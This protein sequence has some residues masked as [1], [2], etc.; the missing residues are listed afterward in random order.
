VNEVRRATAR[1]ENHCTYFSLRML[2]TECVVRVLVDAG[3]DHS[4]HLRLGH[5][6][7]ADYLV[8][9]VYTHGLKETAVGALAVPM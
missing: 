9:Q 3:L 7:T 2:P 1:I 4:L 8:P 5:F 6:M